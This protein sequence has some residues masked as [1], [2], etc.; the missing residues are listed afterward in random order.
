[1]E[2]EHAARVMEAVG[3]G[4]LVV[5]GEGVVRFWNPAAEVVT[6]IGRER[7][8]GHPVTD[9]FATWSTIEGEIPI[10]A[11]GV[12]ARPV[13]LPVDVGAHELWLSFVAVRSREGVVYAF[14]DLT[15]ERRLD[16]A[17]TDFIAT[18]SHELR[19]PLAAVLGDARGIGIPSAER[20]LIF[21]KFYRVDPHLSR[22][23]GGTGLGLYICRELLRR[24]GGRI[25]VRDRTGGGSTFFFELPV[26]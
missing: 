18:I 7:A 2:R 14:R 11:S 23:P 24:M 9:V 3:D 10:A 19:T 5:D 1:A 13:T 17:K 12:A 4:I 26:A 20:D 15:T 8:L 25:G 16:E 21:Q 6:G 22:A